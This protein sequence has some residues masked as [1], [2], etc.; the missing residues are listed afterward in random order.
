MADKP[1]GRAWYALFRE[2]S[3]DAGRVKVDPYGYFSCRLNVARFLDIE[4]KTFN[5]TIYGAKR[6]YTAERSLTLADGTTLSKSAANTDG[7]NAG[8]PVPIRRTVGGRSV[9]IKTGKQIGVPVTGKPKRYHTISFAFPLWATV[10][11]IAEALGE[12][13]PTTKIKTTPTASDVY[14]NFTIKGG[15]T[16]GI[17]QAGAAISSAT[18]ST[19]PATLKQ[20]VT[21]KGGDVQEGAGN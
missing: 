14:P 15:G 21:A 3:G 17:M 4:N 12:L 8:E 2:T 16:Y 19:V 13:I 6:N 11:T 1:L 18:V 10:P 9:I 5:G 7:K 20:R